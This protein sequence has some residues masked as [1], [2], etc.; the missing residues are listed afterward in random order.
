[1]WLIGFGALAA[2]ANVAPLP[3]LT[4]LGISAI[5]S[6]LIGPFIVFLSS[7]LLLALVR[8][9]RG[10]HQPGEKK[11]TGRVARGLVC[12]GQVPVALATAASAFYETAYAE[13][14]VFGQSHSVPWVWL[15]CAILI[16]RSW[17]VYLCLRE[18]FNLRKYRGVFWL[19]VAPLTLA[20][21]GVIGRI[22]R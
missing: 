19:L 10:R 14:I 22:L 3:L 1:M 12:L 20:S 11:M 18:N 7:L 21:S 16:W 9:A 4:V 2:G 8:L 15:L 17:A 13:T 5:S 6:F